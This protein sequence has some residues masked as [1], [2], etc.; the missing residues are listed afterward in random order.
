MMV[1]QCH[2]LVRLCKVPSDMGSAASLTKVLTQRLLA[3]ALL[4]IRSRAAGGQE[5]RNL[6][7]A[8]QP[9]R[10]PQLTAYLIEGIVVKR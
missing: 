2:G 7:D 10:P 1:V 3:I 5:N 9:L 4:T 8:P 6:L